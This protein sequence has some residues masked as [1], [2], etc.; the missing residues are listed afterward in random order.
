[1]TAAAKRLEQEIRQLPLD[2]M[3]ALHDHLVTSIHEKEDAEHLDPA[4]RDEIQRRVK[5]VESGS[6]EGVDAFKALEE[7]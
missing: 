3:L 6:V 2:E 1:M 4:F 7:M 5:E